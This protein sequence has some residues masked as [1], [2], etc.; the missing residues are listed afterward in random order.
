MLASE[1]D[2]SKYVYNALNPSFKISKVLIANK[3]SKKKIIKRRIKKNGLLNVIDQILFQIFISKLGKIFFHNLIK[4]RKEELGLISTDIPEDKIL[5]LEKLNSEKTINTLKNI[6][7]D[8]IIVNG[9]SIISSKVLEC[10][11]AKFINT[12][13]GITPEYRGVYGGYWALRNNDK[14]NFGVTVHMVDKGIDT[15]SIIYQESMDVSKK[16]NFFTYTLCQYSLAIPLL[17]NTILDIKLNQ[18]KP[19]KKKNTISKLYYHPGLSVYI[20]GLIFKSIK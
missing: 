10:T 9:T 8:L 3:E 1:G 13:V 18:L 16:D 19:F 15:G 14:N 2:S 11:Q 17:K 7:A 6:K 4:K 20:S 12:H 5:F